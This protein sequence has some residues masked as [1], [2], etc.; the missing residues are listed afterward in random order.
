VLFPFVVVVTVF[1]FLTA[2]LVC[3]SRFKASFS[4]LIAAICAKISA[5]EGDPKDDS[6]VAF[7]DLAAAQQNLSFFS[8]FHRSRR[9]ASCCCPPPPRFA[10]E[11]EDEKRFRT[12][13]DD[14]FL[15]R[16]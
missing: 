14:V 12:F 11:E 6:S 8:S 16:E 9:K 1:F 3:K 15:K 2:T 4:A 13:D 7:E 5:S 10:D